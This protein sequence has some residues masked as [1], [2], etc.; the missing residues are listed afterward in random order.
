MVGTS[1]SG[2]ESHPHLTEETI[3]RLL[4]LTRIRYK[5]YGEHEK[6]DFTYINLNKIMSIDP[7]EKVIPSYPDHSTLT[8]DNNKTINV[9]DSNEE[10]IQAIKRGLLS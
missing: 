2:N 3:M 8:M 9:W 4:K 1:T 6:G 5:G 10:I 7:M